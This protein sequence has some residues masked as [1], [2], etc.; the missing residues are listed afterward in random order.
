M[1]AAFEAYERALA[2]NKHSRHGT[3]SRGTRRKRQSLGIVEE[4]AVL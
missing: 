4:F 1:V 3:R 2:S